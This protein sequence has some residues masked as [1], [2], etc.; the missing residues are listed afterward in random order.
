MSKVISSSTISLVFFMAVGMAEWMLNRTLMLVSAFVLISGITFVIYAIDKRAAQKGQWRTPEAHLHLL[1]LLG[2]WP[3]AMIA[4]QALR[5]KSQK[6]SFRLVYWMT[7][8]L[9]CGTV[10]WLFTPSG[11]NALNSILG[12]IL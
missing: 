10:V 5:H 11:L 6:A 9:N 7:L 8:I 12:E 2:G 4:Q 3:G 1:A